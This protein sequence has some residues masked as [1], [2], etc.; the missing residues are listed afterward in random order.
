MIPRIILATILILS[1]TQTFSQDS[2]KGR[3]IDYET[4]ETLPG[5]TI[6]DGNNR[7][8]GIISDRGGNFELK[9][10]GNKRNLVLYFVGC[11]AIKFVNIPKRDNNIDFKEIKLVRNHLV[12]HIVIG[13]P[14]LPFSNE[15]LKKDKKLRI[16]VLEKYR[17]NILGKN[18]KPYFEDF[19]PGDK[20]IVFDFGNNE[21]LSQDSIKGRIIDYETNHTIFQRDIQCSLLMLRLNIQTSPLSRRQ[22]LRVFYALYPVPAPTGFTC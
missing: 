19:N 3:I 13:G 8:N 17:I 16:D 10:E 18:V 15:Q 14:S 7:L 21:T 2:I 22:C 11:Y 6:I 20:Y 9:V 4:N 12:D 5:V 1:G